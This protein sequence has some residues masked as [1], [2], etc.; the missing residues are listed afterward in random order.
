MQRGFRMSPAQR[1][2][3]I[4][5]VLLL[6]GGLG[7]VT[8]RNKLFPP[9]S[10]PAAQA[11]LPKAPTAAPGTAAPVPTPAGQLGPGQAGVEIP[12]T[13]TNPMAQ[14]L[15]PGT[16]IDVLFQQNGQ[17]VYFFQQVTIVSASLSTG[18][19]SGSNILI[20]VPIA[21]ATQDTTQETQLKASPQ[22]IYFA[23]E[24]AAP[25]ATPVPT[26]APTPVPTPKPT[27]TP[28]PVVTPTPSTA[29]TSP[30]SSPTP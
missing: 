2:I 28:T 21:T 27:P 14:Y 30:S 29:K 25:V 19:S 22:L 9:A 26:P 16:V 23:I 5:V 11:T 1:I 17:V 13:A 8:F 15:T 6:L 10:T 4:V 18:E 20:Q 7:F 24:P 12:V 3:A